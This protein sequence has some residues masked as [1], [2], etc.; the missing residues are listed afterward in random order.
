MDFRHCVSFVWV[1]E[2]HGGGISRSTGICLRARVVFPCGRVG[3]EGT[4]WF[5]SVGDCCA[6]ACGGTVTFENVVFL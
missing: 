6:S 2:R 3:R 1:A 4:A 5:E